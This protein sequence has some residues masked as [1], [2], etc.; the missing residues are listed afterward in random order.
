MPI[1]KVLR[2]QVAVTAILD[3]AL[4]R[5]F[6]DRDFSELHVQVGKVGDVHDKVKVP[7][8]YVNRGDV[9]LNKMSMDYVV[10]A[11]YP[12]F[13]RHRHGM[14]TTSIYCQCIAASYAST[15]K[16]TD[17]VLNTLV[18]TKDYLISRFKIHDIGSPTASAPEL[19][20]RAGEKRWVAVVSFPLYLEH[21]W[22]SWREDPTLQSILLRVLEDKERQI[23]AELEITGG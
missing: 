20:D 2:I 6:T 11:E 17:A 16:L 9:A 7:A 10:K 14:Y 5:I 19:D 15:E 4:R 3:E 18:A 13:K 1:K 22:T 12:N 8:V 21:A 23:L